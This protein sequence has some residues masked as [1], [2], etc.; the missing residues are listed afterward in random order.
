MKKLALSVSA[1]A[2]AAAAATATAQWLAP[3]YGPYG[4]SGPYAPYAGYAPWG[5]GYGPW[6]AGPM[7]PGQFEAMANQQRDFAEQQGEAIK[8]MMDNQRDWMDRMAPPTPFGPVSSLR[9]EMP[10]MPA[11]GSQPG[12]KMMPR[13]G[14]GWAAREIAIDG[15][16]PLVWLSWWSSHRASQILAMDPTGR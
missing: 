5:S 10:D 9:P 12:M 13:T 3:G 6:G 8:S 7:N 1:V 16:A 11:F 14:T 15:N 2:L 4:F